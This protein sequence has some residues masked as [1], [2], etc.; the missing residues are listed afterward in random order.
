MEEEAEFSQSES[1]TEDII[2]QPKKSVY[3]NPDHLIEELLFDEHTIQPT[4][5]S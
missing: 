4:L 1:E 5:V 2:K 3:K